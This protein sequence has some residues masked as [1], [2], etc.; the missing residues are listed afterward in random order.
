MRR[1]VA[2]LCGPIDRAANPHLW[3]VLAT[4]ELAD[5]NVDVIDPLLLEAN[6]EVDHE[7]RKRA[8]ISGDFGYI[9]SLSDIRKQ[10]LLAVDRSDLLLVNLDMSE[11][12]CGTFE[13]LFRAN[14][15]GKPIFIFSSG[16]KSEVPDWIWWTI[17][18]YR[19]F[20]NLWA[21]LRS[22]GC[23]QENLQRAV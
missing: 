2:Y 15:L 22:I 4:K 23:W 13:E 18:E 14:M 5:L 9:A 8:R 21:A 17:P 11:K 12:P 20:S 7:R 1:N 16:G 10:D 6:I 3:R 19:V